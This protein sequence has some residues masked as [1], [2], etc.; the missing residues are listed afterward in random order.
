[1]DIAR[2]VELHI[3]SLYGRIRR[4][5]SPEEGIVIVAFLLPANGRPHRGGETCFVFDQDVV[6]YL[7]DTDDRQRTDAGVALRNRFIPILPDFEV[8][9]GAK[10]KVYRIDMVEIGR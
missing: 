2:W 10:S 7:H 8:E 5:F 1:M 6:D 3:S 9:T 4:T